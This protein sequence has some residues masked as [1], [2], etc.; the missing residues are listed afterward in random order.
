MKTTLG[1]VRFHLQVT[2]ENMKAK[3]VKLAVCHMYR[4]DGVEL[5]PEMDP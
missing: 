2:D 1:N 3:D 4:S 5:E